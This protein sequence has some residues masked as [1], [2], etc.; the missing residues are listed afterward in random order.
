MGVIK[1]FILIILAI[2]GT[3]QLFGQCPTITALT[4]PTEVAAGSNFDVAALGLGNMAMADNSEADF[5]IEFVYVT[6]GTPPADPYSGGTSL[7]TVS[8]ANLSGV[9]NPGQFATLNTASIP[10][11]DTYQVCAI[12]DD[13]PADA[14]CRPSVCQTIIVNECAIMINSVNV[15]DCVNDEYSLEVE[16]MYTNAPTG[17]INIT[18]EGETV[19]NFTPMSDADNDGIICDEPVCLYKQY[20]AARPLKLPA[21]AP[22]LILAMAGCAMTCERL[23]IFRSQNLIPILA[24][25]TLPVAAGK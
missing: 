15:L 19:Q 14:N 8:N 17:D 16:V 22:R 3:Q 20:W 25:L 7:G 12:L 4:A 21:S 9:T 2:V 11:A 23:P 5:G 10:T 13:T 24:L 6:G 18:P 1:K